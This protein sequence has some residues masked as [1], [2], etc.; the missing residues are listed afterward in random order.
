VHR[1]IKLENIL[2]GQNLE[3]KICDFNFAEEVSK[4]K[5]IRMCGTEGY[6][7]PELF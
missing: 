5:V 7:A 1:D 4:A 3:L 6:I 2:V